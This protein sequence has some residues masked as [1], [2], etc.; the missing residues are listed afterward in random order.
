MSNR[1]KYILG[2]V[3]A[4]VIV[5][6]LGAFL[7][8]DSIVASSTEVIGTELTGTE[9]TVEGASV[10]PF[11]GA[12]T[13]T[14]FRVANPGG[15]G[16]DH[17]MQAD[18]ISVDL[19]VSS[20]WSDPT[21]VETVVVEGPI[22]NVAQQGTENNLRTILQN[23][24]RAAEAGS[25]S[26]G[27]LIVEHFLMEEGTVDLYAEVGG[28]R[29]ARVD[30][31]SVEMRDLGADEG[32]RAVGAVVRQVVGRVFGAALEAAGGNWKDRAEDAIRDFFD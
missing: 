22:V 1:W 20:L 31:P 24:D 17:A 30:L 13:I 4:V 2:G 26:E 14:G 3:F 5:V 28:E 10:S 16:R 8:I 15:Y 27:T 21:V 25:S 9:V 6:V 29:S 19:D 23:V 18:A 11:S 12:G 7:W 32:G